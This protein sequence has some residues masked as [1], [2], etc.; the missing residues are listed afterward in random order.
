[1]SRPRSL[2]L[3]ASEISAFGYCRRSCC[4]NI[5]K[6]LRGRITVGFTLSANKIIKTSSGSER[7]G[8]YNDFNRFYN[9]ELSSV[10]VDRAFKYLEYLEN[11]P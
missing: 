8:N 9:T 6:R 3:I 2:A 1:M 7:I 10:K 5:F 4:S 11:Y